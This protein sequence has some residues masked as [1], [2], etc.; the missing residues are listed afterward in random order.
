M[1][2]RNKIVYDIATFLDKADD[3]DFIRLLKFNVDYYRALFIRRDFER[4][5]SAS[6]YL[7][8]IVL[9]VEYV[10]IPMDSK[11]AADCGFYQTK[12][13]VPVPIRVKDVAPF[14]H[15]GTPFIP[16][17]GIM[18]T[19]M[20]NFINPV[21]LLYQKHLYDG[22]PLYTYRNGKLQ[23][24]NTGKLCYITIGETAFEDPM[25]ALNLSMAESKCYNDD[26]PYPLPA[27]L[28]EAIITGFRD[29]QLRLVPVDTNIIPVEELPKKPIV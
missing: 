20:F 19:I 8:S 17:S 27:D 18:K 16:S 10:D 4:N 22:I 29:K 26:D 14:T 12:D 28:I 15:V 25:V 23:F 9:E 13:V 1:V 2:T 21:A 6:Q 3:V 5:G 11:V 24:Y 7:T